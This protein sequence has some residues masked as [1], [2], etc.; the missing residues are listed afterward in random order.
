MTL[1]LNCNKVLR[2]GLQ[3]HIAGRDAQVKM[4]YLLDAHRLNVSLM[5]ATNPVIIG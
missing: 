4:A 2:Y 1:D 3:Y 5:A